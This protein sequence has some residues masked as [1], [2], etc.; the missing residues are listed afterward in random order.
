[1]SGNYATIATIAN[2]GAPQVSILANAST[3]RCQER[4]RQSRLLKNSKGMGV[5]KKYPSVGT[6][7][8]NTKHVW[9]LSELAELSA[10]YKA[11]H[12]TMPC[13][14]IANM[15]YYSF[16][17]QLRHDQNQDQDQDQATT[18][19]HL[20]TIQAIQAKLMDCITLQHADTFGYAS[21]PTQAHKQVWE[22]LELAEKHS[23]ML[24]RNAT[25][26][27]PT[28]LQE[29]LQEQDEI[30]TPPA[31]IP[32]WNVHAT[33]F[34]T[35]DAEIEATEPPKKRRKIVFKHNAK[36]EQEERSES[37]AVSAP[38]A[39]AT[40]PTMSKAD[41][42]AGIEELN[43]LLEGVDQARRT[44]K[45]NIQNLVHQVREHNTQIGELLG[46]IQDAQAEIF[47]HRQ[48]ITHIMEQIESIISPVPLTTPSAAGSAAP[49]TTPVCGKC[50]K[51]IEGELGGFSVHYADSSHPEH[52][53]YVCDEC[54]PMSPRVLQYFEEA[55]A[56]DAEM[57]KRSLAAFANN[58][59]GA[60][61]GYPLDYDS[62]IMDDEYPS[63]TSPQSGNMRGC[64]DHGEEC[65]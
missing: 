29:Q 60:E 2:D 28:Q 1:M 31:S 6:H 61:C 36:E 59:R 8:R 41:F 63:S 55:Y 15:L 3:K 18:R 5:G 57:A 30:H 48:A 13:W 22:H 20:P 34:Y 26:S 53:T 42:H 35:P 51:N 14:N 49:T 37:P 65:S 64:Y 7:R 50:T 46:G 9:Q 45:A 47:Q 4:N 12:T 19:T 58:C 24:K 17:E 33:S 56:E 32:I 62:D 38:T 25:V 43:S 52:G 11:H 44:E 10:A 27:V 39:P 23:E 54:V 40:R 16:G 21:R